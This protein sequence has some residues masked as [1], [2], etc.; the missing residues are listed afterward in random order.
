MCLSLKRQRSP[1]PGTAPD[2]AGGSAG[3]SSAC[4]GGSGASSPRGCAATC[5]AAITRLRRHT[6][7]SVPFLIAWCSDPVRG[8]GEADGHPGGALVAADPGRA[9]AW[10]CR[11]SLPLGADIHMNVLNTSYDRKCTIYS[12]FEHV[13]VGILVT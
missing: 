7:H 12:I 3:S 5:R 4:S 9:T 8:R 13:A 10:P 2:P 11:A 1:N 6:A